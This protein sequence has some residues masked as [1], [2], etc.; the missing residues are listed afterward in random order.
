VTPFG[1][2]R[3]VR[4]FASSYANETDAVPLDGYD[5]ADRLTAITD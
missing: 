4:R 2:V 5:A 3:R 1:S